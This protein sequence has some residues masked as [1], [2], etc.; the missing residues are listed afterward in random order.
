ML[1]GISSLNS[2]L[3]PKLAF[4][5][6]ITVFVLCI[7]LI[8]YSP[9]IPKNIHLNIGDTA[10]STITSPQ[11]IEFES[12]SDKLINQKQFE[13]VK[14]RTGKIYTISESVN[15]EIIQNIQLTFEELMGKDI[16]SLSI[17]T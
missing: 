8:I 9:F 14:N 6:L 1:T 10:L 3:T 11:I 15:S 13:Q 5:A 7:S 16:N 4:Y 2:K 17:S 12:T